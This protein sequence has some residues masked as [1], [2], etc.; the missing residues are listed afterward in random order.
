MMKQNLI[1][2]FFLPKSLLAQSMCVVR[3]TERTEMK[4][5]RQTVHSEKEVENE[6]RIME[7]L[8]PLST[9]KIP[10]SKQLQ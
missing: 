2:I 4:L 8:S 9:C 7:F 3:F 10:H 5:C 6:L 1:H